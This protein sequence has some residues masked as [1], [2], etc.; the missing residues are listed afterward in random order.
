MSAFT[1]NSIRKKLDKELLGAH[2][3]AQMLPEHRQLENNDSIK[4]LF[5][6]SA[7][8]ILL[9]EEDGELYTYLI[10]RSPLMRHHPG[11][12]GFPGG[13]IELYEDAIEAAIRESEEEIGLERD[14]CVII[15]TISDVEI[16]IS[17]FIIHPI[18]AWTT[19]Q[20]FQIKSPNEIS[21]IIKVSI[22]D[23][24]Q[25]VGNTTIQLNNKSVPVPAYIL[26]DDVIW[27]ASAMILSEL[28]KLLQEH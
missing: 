8:L 19:Q 13:K 20:N 7:V 16:P 14:Q 15:R 6:H 10:Q 11:Q 9:R 12:I 18:V 3:H 26:N 1:F 27:G 24:E 4:H 22:S 23:L 21:R 2:A 25:S 28:L 5:Q 17:K